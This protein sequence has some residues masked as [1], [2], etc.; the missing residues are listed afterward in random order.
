MRFMFLQPPS[1]P[2]EPKTVEQIY[3][4]IHVLARVVQS[5]PKMHLEASACRGRERGR[6]GRAFRKQDLFENIHRKTVA[7]GVTWKC[8]GMTS[9]SA[10]LTS[11]S[12]VLTSVVPLRDTFLI[13]SVFIKHGG[14]QGDTTWCARVMY[15]TRR[16]TLL[17]RPAHSCALKRQRLSTHN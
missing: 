4:E 2:L 3:A 15:C 12:G 7:V 5:V 9:V 1:A 16:H 6:T 14:T 11:S 8:V 17:L 10:I 13:R